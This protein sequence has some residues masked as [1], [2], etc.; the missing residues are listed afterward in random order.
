M[1]NDLK[2]DLKQWRTR[3]ADALA[4]ERRERFTTTSGRVVKEV[5]TADDLDEE[6]L[7]ED[8]GLPGDPPYTRGSTPTG[9]RG[10][11]WDWEF[12]AGFGAASDANRRYRYLLEQGGTGGVSMALDLP[13]QVGLD[14]DHP[15]AARD[16][17][18]VGVSL[19]TLDDVLAAFDGMG[20]AEIEKIFTTANCIAPVAL[21]WFICL[22]EAKNESPDTFTVTIQNDPLKDY[23][24]RGTQFLPV[25]A[26]VELAC[27]VIQYVVEADYPWYP[28]SLSGAHMK[29]AGGTC[30]EEAAFTLA[31][32]LA[33]MDN[34]VA[35]GVSARKVAERMELHFSTD[36]DF[37]EEVAKYRVIRRVWT[38]LLEDRYS[39]TGVPPRLHGVASGVPLT[40]QQPL[41][42]VVRITME[43]LA[44]VFGGVAQTRTAC[45]DEALAI[46]T[47]EAVKL[48]L[49]TNQIVAV[50]T[51]VADV[52]D[53]L[54]G[55]YYLERL[56]AD[57]YDEVRE[58][59]RKIEDLG[60]A[61]AAVESGYFSA[62]LAAGAYR[63][64]QEF[65]SGDRLVVGVNQWVEDEKSSI[66]VF[67]VDP[68]AAERQRQ[69]LAEAKTKRSANDVATSLA[70]VAKAAREGSN[71][72]PAVLAA[73]RAGATIGEICDTWRGVFGEWAPTAS[74]L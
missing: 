13:T 26:A 40:A 11:L 24:A 56:T 48:S 47:E 6:T 1:P 21:A 59:L 9:Y 45:Y 3:H 23:V 65:E 42:N 27:D 74:A 31:N 49:R 55:S 36:M 69:R 10:K 60:G 20:L 15:L 34:L 8:L 17:G 37:F 25:S 63:Q 46:P 64:Q 66:N 16:V 4:S 61:I 30:A 50:E 54:G 29:Q 5:Y 57:M 41:N 43:V 71:S 35:R 72:V 7:R 58:M 52:V 44:Q 2:T 51:G 62:Q 33:Y 68:E 67:K 53:P 32:G 73:V 28:I 38:E 14:P 39:V 18:R 19:S 12:Y 70:G 22:A